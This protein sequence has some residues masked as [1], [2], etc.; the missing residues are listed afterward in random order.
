[1]DDYQ[2]IRQLRELKAIKPQK[3]WKVALKQNLL[4]EIK[5]PLSFYL[6][7][8]LLAGGIFLFFLAGIFVF[9]QK[10]L[11]GQ[12]LYPVKKTIE[13]ASQFFLSEQK[14][15]YYE[16]ELTQKRLKELEEVVK[17]NDVSKIS[18]ALSEFESTKNKAQK[19][20]SEIVSKNPSSAKEIVFRFSE[21]EKKEKDILTA[22]GI[23][24]SKKESSQKI[25]VEYLIKSFQNSSLTQNQMILFEEAKKDFEKGDYSS[26]LE[27][28]LK[29]SQIK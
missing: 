20:V 18:C 28:L 11:P 5:T 29:A 25:L 15:P 27:K 3:E 26:S 19:K 4:K 9:S 1:M 8:P 23:D 13:T 14:K 16:L 24:D 12:P 22:L 7:R 2:I 17:Q 10:A 6:F 21:I